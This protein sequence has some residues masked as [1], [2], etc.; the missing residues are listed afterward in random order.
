MVRYTGQTTQVVGMPVDNR[1][2]P[3]TEELIGNFVN[4]VAVRSD[5]ADNPR[6]EKLLRQV[7]KAVVEVY[8]HR[9]FP[10]REAVDRLRSVGKGG[11]GDVFRVVFAARSDMTAAVDLQ[12]LDLEPIEVDHLGAKFDLVLAFQMR[13][14]RLA[15]VAEYDR[16]LFSA[17]S[18][19]KLGEDYQRILDAVAA[20]PARRIEELPITERRGFVLPGQSGRREGVIPPEERLHE[21]FAKR[22]AQTPDAVAVTDSDTQLS[23]GVLNQK[24]NQLARYLRRLGVG[25]EVAVGIYMDRSADLVLAMLA[26]LKAGG[27]YVP[28]DANYPAQRLDFMLGD[29]Q[30]GVV[31]TH[32]R[33][34]GNIAGVK[35][36]VVC[37]DRDGDL[38]RRESRKGLDCRVQAD[39]IAYTIYTSGTT[40]NPKGVLVSHRN[41]ARLL[42]STWSGFEFDGSDVWSLCHSPSFDFSVWEIWGCLLYGGR[43]IVVPAAT[44]R[45]PDAL[46]ELLVR[47]QVTV[48]NQ[49]PSAFRHLTYIAEDITPGKTA[50]R[51]VIFGGEALCGRDLQSWVADHGDRGPRLINMYG[52]TETTVHVTYCPLKA[53]DCSPALPDSIGEAIPDMQAYILGSNMQMVP[54]GVEGELYIGGGGVTR[55]YH[56]HA[57]HTADRF[58]PD[59]FSGSEGAR[60]YRTGDRARRWP[61]G[62][63]EYRGR[64]DSQVKIR[65]FRIELGEIENALESHPQVR[66]SVVRTREVASGGRCLDAYIVSAKAGAATE[67]ELRGFLRARLPDYMLPGH[68]VEIDAVPLTAN[69]KIDRNALPLPAGGNGIGGGAQ[70]PAEAAGKLESQ[71]AE[72]WR[73]ILGVEAVGL[74]DGFFD[75]GGD[76]LAIVRVAARLRQALGTE[77]MIADL[78]AHP[79]I[80]SLARHLRR[81]DG[82]PAERDAGVSRAKRIRTALSAQE[83]IHRQKRH[84]ADPASQGKR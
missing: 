21:L 13:D 66:R 77:L 74:H 5:L 18:V 55:G 49:T 48:L 83:Q 32:E 40:G 75:I 14:G 71:I 65:G 27:A 53:Q 20:S 1:T 59:P 82:A 57:A 63:V 78:F 62:K 45:A 64:A 68:F 42:A 50:L 33:L 80:A 6:F 81:V 84:Q 51:L 23:Y 70:Q 26:V 37:L 3:E 38:V 25:P 19:E 54:S 29:G 31:L 35:G 39:N 58:V 22:A 47:E 24:A 15:F 10:M 12:G 36:H 76:S 46:C 2:H 56:G 73:E 61:Q 4:T 72:V 16:D 8:E 52:I 17:G 28:L 69:G 30:I 34:E 41:V 60:L 9:E 7:H 44:V 79:T 11:A 43:L 67:K